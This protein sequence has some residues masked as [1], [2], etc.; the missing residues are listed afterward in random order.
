SLRAAGEEA[1]R[2]NEREHDRED[3]Q[4]LHDERAEQEEREN[5]ERDEQDETHSSLL[6]KGRPRAGLFPPKAN[7]NRCAAPRSYAG[8]RR[9][10]TVAIRRRRRSRGPARASSRRRSPT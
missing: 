6:S 8:R 10:R 3:E 5:D 1:D 7:L 9:A 2:P 4:P